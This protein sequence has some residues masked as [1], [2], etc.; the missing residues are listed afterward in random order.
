M[1]DKL[2]IG[3]YKTISQFKRDFRLIVENCKQYNGSDNG[4]CIDVV[5]KCFWI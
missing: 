1:E 2:E 4:K 5:I 3:S